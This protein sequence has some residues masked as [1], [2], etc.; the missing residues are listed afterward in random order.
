MKVL[1][2]INTA[3]GVIDIEVPIAIQGVEGLLLKRE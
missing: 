2:R 3:L 1:E